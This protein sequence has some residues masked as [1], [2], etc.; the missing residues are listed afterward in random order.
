MRVDA[1]SPPS[2]GGV[3][4]SAG[5]VGSAKSRLCR[6]DHPVCAPSVASRHFL[7][8]QPPLLC[9]EGNT[10]Y[11]GGDRNAGKLETLD[12]SVQESRGFYI[13]NEFT[14]IL[15]GGFASFGNTDRLLHSHE[16]PI[17]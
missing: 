11:L 8:A 9:E 15:C 5:V 3:A 1:Y 7:L 6:S 4:R 2:R 17:E 13:L 12:R 16:V 10:Q 14:Q